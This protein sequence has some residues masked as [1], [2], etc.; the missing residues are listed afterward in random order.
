M[1][2]Q[3]LGKI[4]SNHV[5]ETN[6]RRVVLMDPRPVS[7]S[8]TKSRLAA[9]ALNNAAAE[10]GLAQRG[11][12]GAA[13]QLED[14]QRLEAVAAALMKPPGTPTVKCGE[15]VSVSGDSGPS[16]EIA[17][18]LR[19][20][21]A[22]VIEASVARTDLLLSLPTDIVAL[23]IDASASAKANNSF[24]KMLAHQ[25]ALIH[26]LAMKTG[27]RALDFEKREG[28]Y[29]DALKLADSV[30]LARLAQATSRLSSAFQDGL[31]TLQRLRNGSAQTM[32]IR[33]V[34]VEAGGQAVIGNVKP[35]GR[36]PDRT[37]GRGNPG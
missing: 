21:D 25:L 4:M 36:R 2:L 5:L 29:G 12:P 7:K 15:V 37:T 28:E 14:A 30:E 33:H 24:E 32:T 1:A 23:A 22:A 20:P 27:A 35:G 31:M 19:D 13:G 8:E 3:S 9:R 18:T 26:V 6:R 10:R 16:C 34:T 11:G 17:D